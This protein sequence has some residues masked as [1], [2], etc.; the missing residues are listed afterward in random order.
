MDMT[1]PAARNPIDENRSSLIGK[2]IDR[3]D[4]RL[5]VTGKAPYAHEVQ[6]APGKPA[7]GFIVEATIAR[8]TVA[9]IDA[10]AAEKAPGVLLVMTHRNAPKQAPWGPI[11]A[12]DRF[13]RATPQLANDKVRYYG[14]AVAF[15]VAESFEIA[16]AAAQLIR[17]RYDAEPGEYDLAAARG[18]AEKPKDDEMQKADSRIGDFDGAFAAAPVQVDAT[19]TTP[20]HIHA[21][22]EPH[23][24]LA[25]WSGDRVTVHCASQLLES[26]QNAVANTLQIPPSKV[27]IVSRYIGGG[28][29]GK[30]P[31]YG[32]LMLSAMAARQL[33]RPVKTALTR[34][35]MFHFTTH[36]S[37]T[38]QRLRLG[39]TPDGRLTAIAHDSHSHSARFDDFY[40]TASAQT[41]SLYAAP[42]R[43]TTHRVVKLDLPVSDSTRAPG[44]AVGMLAL[45][46]AM[47]ELAEKLRL[48][49]IELRLRN[50]PA[51]DP[52]KNIPF[53]TRQLARCMREG[54]ERFGWSRRNAVPGTVREGRRLIGM[55]FAAATRNNYLMDAK[56]T[57]SLDRQGVLTARMAMTD[58]GTGSYTVLTQVAAEMLGLPVQN[59]RME[60]GDSDFPETPG[61]GGSW[62]AAS[63][64]SA[65][66]DACTNLRGQLAR[67]LGAKPDEVVFADGRASTRTRCETLGA[68]AGTIGLRADGQ[69]G[70]GD[71]GKKFSQQAY[72]AHFAEVAVDMDTGEIRLRRMLGMFA[73]GRILN[74]KTATSQA[75]GAMIWGVGS[76][77]FEDAV[78]DPRYGAFVN[79]DLAEYH[80]P[81]HADIPAVEAVFLDEVDDKTNPL[82]I[83]G[84]GELGICGAGAAVANAVYNATGVRIR[85]YPLTLD[86]VM[87]LQERRA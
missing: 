25:W 49:P 62:G 58:I 48:D 87:R 13:A 7:Y 53:S 42:N 43:L 59:V 24:T 26:A 51:M 34:Q 56:C 29:G 36:R 85:D 77:L 19:Y 10:S 70:K 32:D 37:Q 44:E 73:A 31:V 66:F 41:R 81:A 33:Q 8:G 80:V 75:T 47:D 67:R 79:H 60:L 72:G 17:I 50:E 6:E 15:V 52:E 65:L 86:K 78:I 64:G 45:E 16:R 61:S 5:K 63:A 4:G 23:A 69:I 84:V 38:I 82:K 3:V 74:M 46:Q 28:F 76:A 11:D 9:E 18:K 39:A 54:A 22:M 2:P 71:M 1:A 21:Q 27:R 40:E 12:K 68:L 14:E 57:V 30:L 83:K 35:Q 20:H 55:G